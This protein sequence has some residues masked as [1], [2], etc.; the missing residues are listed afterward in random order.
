[1]NKSRRFITMLLSVVMVLALALTG[2]GSGSSDSDS[3]A[4]SSS[5]SSEGKGIAAEDLRVALI[6]NGSITD[7]SWN[8]N[9]YN[10]LK[11]NA[12]DMGFEFNYIENVQQADMEAS[13]RD[14][15]EQGYNLIIAHGSQFEDAM[16][17]VASS[18]PDIYFFVYN[19]EVFGDN[20][21]SLRNS[22][23]EN[24]F[25]TGAL[26]A[27]VT[28]T[29]IIGWIGAVEVPTTSEVLDGYTAGAKYA[30]PD[31]EIQSAYVGSYN[32][33]AKAKEL[34]LTMIEQGADVIQSNANQGTAGVI[35]A[36]YEK[37]TDSGLMLIGNTRDQYEDAPEFM[38]TSCT[39]DFAAAYR[40][41]LDEVVNGEFEG[42]VQ[43]CTVANGV[44]GIAPYHDFE[45]KLTDEQKDYIEQVKQDLI[46][47]KLNAELPCDYSAYG[48]PNE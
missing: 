1:M 13:I 34:T 40:L 28:K 10:A 21:C 37:G 43:L 35:E 44:M 3:S 29:G 23:D 38:L 22:A 26:A 46:D 42:T 9:G 24:A 41:I 39:I 30:N 7:A 14:F 15:C 4:D 45:D 11:E 47:G 31:V 17:A 48:R 19:A 36:A 2:C 18:Y 27:T 32:D 6:L 12:D 25:L 16:S 5:G 33:T 20:L 8:A